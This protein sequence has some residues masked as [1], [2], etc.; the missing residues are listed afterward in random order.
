MVFPQIGCYLNK[1]SIWLDTF[2][3]L[4]LEWDLK[5]SKS[6][7]V[8]EKSPNLLFVAYKSKKYSENEQ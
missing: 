6:Y 8:M 1:V 5:I 3:A 4:G 7:C 2:F